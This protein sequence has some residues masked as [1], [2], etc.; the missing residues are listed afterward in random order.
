MPSVSKFQYNEKANLLVKNLDKEIS[1]QALFDTFKAF[2]DI[3]SLKLETYNDGSSKGYAY[4]QFVNEEDAQK[5]LDQMNGQELHGKKLE[6]N[7]HERKDKRDVKDIAAPSK[8]NNLFVKNL[9]A[10]TS[11][12]QLASLFS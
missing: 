2:G 6:I 9:P 10:G 1:Q 11:D 7:K 12:E 8:Y 3:Q 5:A 4:I